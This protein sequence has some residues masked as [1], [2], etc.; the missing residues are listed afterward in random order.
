MCREYSSIPTSVYDQAWQATYR[1]K[2]IESE[3]QDR[4]LGHAAIKDW[5]RRHFK[6][7]Y[8]WCHWLHL[9]G[10]QWFHEFPASQFNSV[11]D[12]RDEIERQVIHCFWDGQENLE[13]FFVR[14][15]MR[16]AHRAGASSALVTR[17]QRGPAESAREMSGVLQHG[18]S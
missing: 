11:M 13:I 9:T 10:Q 7:F 4:D 2:W 6:R 17:H 12:P 1:H 5:S 18:G 3:R 15:R 14:A 8:R 16:L